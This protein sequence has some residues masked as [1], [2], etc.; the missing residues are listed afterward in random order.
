MLRAAVEVM[1]VIREVPPAAVEEV[2]ESEQAEGGLM[3][4]AE[5]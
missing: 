2:L 1:A 4:Q 3:C 5:A